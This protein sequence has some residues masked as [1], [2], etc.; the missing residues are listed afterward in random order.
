MLQN[1]FVYFLLEFFE[2]V[3]FHSVRNKENKTMLA[4]DEMLQTFYKSEINTY[5]V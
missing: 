2:F 4:Y 1:C 5:L 3:I